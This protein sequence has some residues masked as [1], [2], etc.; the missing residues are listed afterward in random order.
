VLDLLT[1]HAA[2][3]NFQVRYSWQVGDVAIWDERCTQHFAVADY[4]PERREMGR[5]AVVV[6][7]A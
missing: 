4:Q 5:V 1:T 3:P 7:G 6:A 2:H